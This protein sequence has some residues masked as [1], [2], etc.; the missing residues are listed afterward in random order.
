[1]ARENPRWG[2]R[3]VHGELT[4]LGY[5]VSDSSVRRILR[6]KQIGPA[7]RGADLDL[8]G[9]RQVLDCPIFR[10]AHPCSPKRRSLGLRRGGGLRSRL[11]C[12]LACFPYAS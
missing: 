2:Y 3:R 11:T 10:V 4:R 9:K 7:P 5:R 1:M 8:D 12:R 6:S